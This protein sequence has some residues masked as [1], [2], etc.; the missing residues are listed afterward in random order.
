MSLQRI[1]RDHPD[2]KVHRALIASAVNGLIDGKLDVIGTV[3]LAA[4]ATTTTV[5]DNKF[6]SGMVPLFVPTTS[7]AAG[8]LSGLYVSAR[9]KGEF[10]LTHASTA[11]TDR[12]FLYVR[13]G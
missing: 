1:P 11:T 12:T 7:N 4:S 13:L 9:T 8:A 5:S 2:E 3:T 6:E 10:T